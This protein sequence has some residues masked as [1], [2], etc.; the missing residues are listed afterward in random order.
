MPQGLGTGQLFVENFDNAPLHIEG[1]C[2]WYGSPQQRAFMN[3]IEQ[4]KD[5]WREPVPTVTVH[6]S[7]STGQP[8]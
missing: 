8:K 3:E 2:M 5:I 6:T 4:Y 7:G 1:D